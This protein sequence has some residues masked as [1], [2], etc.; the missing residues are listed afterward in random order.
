MPAAGSGG[1]S[2]RKTHSL[3]A[4]R[5]RG[6]SWSAI[7]GQIQDEK[8]T[9]SQSSAA[10]TCSG[11]ATTKGDITP[12]FPPSSHPTFSQI[13]PLAPAMTICHEWV[14]W[15]TTMRLLCMRPFCTPAACRS[16]L[17]K[18]TRSRPFITLRHARV[19]ACSPPMP[20]LMLLACPCSLIIGIQLASPCMLTLCRIPKSKNAAEY[21][22]WQS[23]AG[24]GP[25]LHPAPACGQTVRKMCSNVH[26]MTSHVLPDATTVFWENSAKNMP[27]N[28]L[29]F[30]APLFRSDC[31]KFHWPID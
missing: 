27:G 16:K 1:A 12:L 25:V 24:F 18:Y 8:A 15:P 4:L 23:A 2:A 20:S 17:Q 11:S 28:Q 13:H 6:P 7:T 31:F 5:T 21:T 22:P 3:L 30:T 14:P 9:G 10:S 26:R 19:P 29:A